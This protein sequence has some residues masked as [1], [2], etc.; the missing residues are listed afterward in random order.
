MLASPVLARRLVQSKCARRGSEAV[1]IDDHRFRSNSIIRSRLAASS[2][3]APADRDGVNTVGLAR[4]RHAIAQRRAVPPA[5]RG[6]HCESIGARRIDVSLHTSTK[7]PPSPTITNG[8]K[9]SLRKTA[10]D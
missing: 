4:A 1:L 6:R 10:R 7:I 3:N 5:S 2:D 8:P 9:R